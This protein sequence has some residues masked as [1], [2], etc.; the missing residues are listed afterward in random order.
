M[1]AADV[2]NRRDLD[3]LLYEWLELGVIL[4]RPRFAAHDEEE[5]GAMLDQVQKLALEGLAPYLRLSDLVEPSLDAGGTVR[6]PPEIV[7][8]VRL[9]ADTGLFGAAFEED[10]GGLGLPYLAYA[11]AMGVLMG[12]SV[13]ITSFMLLTVANARLIAERGSSSQISRFARPQIAGEALGTMCLSEPHAGSSLGDIRTRAEFDGEDQYGHRFRVFGSK[14]WI[15]AGDHD[16]TDQIVHLVLAKVPDSSGKLVAGTR[17]TS[18]L[19]VPKILPDGTANDIRVAGLNHK[20]GYRG[21]PNCALNFG[22]G[23]VEPDGRRGA[24]GW[25]IG[26]S[27]H[28]LSYMFQMMNEARIAVGLGGAMLAYRGYLMALAYSRTRIQGRPPARKDGPPIAIVYH[29]DVRRMLLAQKSYAEGALALVL[30]S[31]RLLDEGATA[32]TQPDRDRASTLLEF[33]TPITKTWPSEWGQRALDFAIQIHGGA[34]YTRDFE[35]EQLYRDNRLNSIHEGTTGIQAID[36]VDRKL[37][38]HAARGMDVLRNRVTATIQ[39]LL[40]SD[41]LAAQATALN[42][43]WAAIHRAVEHVRQERDDARALMHATPLLFAFGHAVVGW[44]WLDQA[45]VCEHAMTGG[46]H[47]AELNFRQGKLRACQYFSEF[48]LPKIAA[49]LAPVLSDTD[50]TTSMLPEQFLG[51]LA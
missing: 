32:T 29:A 33:L 24:I 30:Y 50:V 20:M 47:G 49:W 25:L 21:I 42:D 51:E 2:I 13:A 12:G 19:I 46:A 36:L 38:R 48:E 41:R 26:E 35:V 22:D 43:A 34:G 44:L 17:G 37:R 23:R 28:G 3:F 6:V 11:A 27:G 4:R 9:I 5:I 45:R 8:A 1:A 18:L 31:A 14:M 15:S 39:A 7:R 10:R 16:V 40:S